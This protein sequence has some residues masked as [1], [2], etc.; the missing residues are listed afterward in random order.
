MLFGSLRGNVDSQWAVCGGSAVGTEQTCFRLRKASMGILVLIR[1]DLIIMMIS[2]RCKMTTERHKNTSTDA[3][4]HKEAQID[5]K[6]MQN[7]I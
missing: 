3:N 5:L 4:D 7:D 6:E 2:Q 1:W